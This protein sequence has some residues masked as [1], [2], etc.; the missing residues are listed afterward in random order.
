MFKETARSQTK[1]KKPCMSCTPVNRSTR[2]CE[3]CNSHSKM[4]LILKKNNL[5]ELISVK[6]G[7]THWAPGNSC[8]DIRQS[9]DSVGD[10][11]FWIDPAAS[12]VPIK[13]YCDMTTDNGM[14]N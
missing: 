12:G 3:L 4:E 9:E 5:S 8:K 7:S 13:V 10:G 2:Y 1:S 14:E 11:E 6:K